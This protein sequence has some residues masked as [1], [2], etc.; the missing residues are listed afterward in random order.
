MKKPILLAA[1][2]AA[3]ALTPAFAQSPAPAAAAPAAFDID[4]LHA[5]D[6][7][8]PEVVES[9]RKLERDPALTFAVFPIAGD[10]SGAVAGSVKA[11]V[12]QAGKRCIEGRADPA[13]KTLVDEFFS[14]EIGRAHV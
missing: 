13:W 11:A 6:S 14:D 7:T 5:I 1:A 10:R 9:L 3:L 2:V 8:V 4:E 12:T